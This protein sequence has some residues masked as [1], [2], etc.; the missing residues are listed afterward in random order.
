MSVCNLRA[1]GTG[2][3]AGAE[4]PNQAPPT[5]PGTTSANVG[6][7]GKLLLL[8]SPLTAVSGEVRSKSFPDVP[9]LAEV[10]PGVVGGAWFGISA[11]AKL[12]VP[13]ALKLQTDIQA[14]LNSPDMLARLSEMGMTPMPLVGQDFVGFLQAENRRWGPLIRA[15][16]ISV[17]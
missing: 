3:L 2:N 6:T 17:E 8:T 16:K 9:T 4:I 7:S 10:V 15:G 13:V 5:T 14:V 1:T 11:P 12:P